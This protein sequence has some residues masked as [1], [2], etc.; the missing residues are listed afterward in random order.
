LLLGKLIV[1]R[2]IMRLKIL[3]IESDALNPSDSGTPEDLAEFDVLVEVLLYEENRE[4][5]DMLF[6]FTVASPVAL[7]KRPV[8]GFIQPTLILDEFSWQVIRQHVEK[9]LMHVLSCES[10]ECVVFK[11]SGLMRPSSPSSYDWKF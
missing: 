11:F 3:S 9:L 5:N 8:G 7:V 2:T 10:W 4:T 6:E 1:V